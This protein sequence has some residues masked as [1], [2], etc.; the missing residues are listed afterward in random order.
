MRPTIDPL[1]GLMCTRQM[2]IPSRLGNLS[3]GFYVSFF[4]VSDN[5]NEDYRTLYRTLSRMSRY[6]LTSSQR[7]RFD[8][9]KR[10]GVGRSRALRHTEV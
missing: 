5:S 7:K 3:L 10:S 2:T 9:R 8:I 4:N 6:T 1:S